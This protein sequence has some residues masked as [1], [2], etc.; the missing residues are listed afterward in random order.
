MNTSGEEALTATSGSMFQPRM[1]RG[2]VAPL[3][4]RTWSAIQIRY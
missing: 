2:K 3:Y 4:L 1:V